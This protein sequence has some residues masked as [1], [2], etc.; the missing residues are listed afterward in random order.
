MK[1][2]FGIWMLGLFLIAGCT[3][4][5][6]SGNPFSDPPAYTN[7]L[8]EESSPYLI[9]QAYQPVDWR[10]WSKASLAEAQQ[11]DKLLLI[12]IG[13]AASHWCQV[14]DQSVFADTVVAREMNTHFLPIKVDREERP[15]LAGWYQRVC[16]LSQQSCGWP[17]Q[18]I[19][20]PDGRPLAVSSMTDVPN[21]LR[22]LKRYQTMYQ[23]QPLEAEIRS[24][25]LANQIHQQE[26]VQLQPTRAHLT[27]EDLFEAM[28]EI[29]RDM[30]SNWGGM[31]EQ[32]KY[33]R[34]VML[35]FL[36]EQH[37]HTHNEWVLRYFNKSLHYLGQGGIY[38]QIGGGF[39]HRAR[40]DA[41]RKPEFEKLLTDNALLLGVFADA[42]RLNQEP[43][44]EQIM[45]ETIEFLQREMK[46]DWGYYSSLAADSEGE[47][48]RYYLWTPV[49]LEVV[50]GEHIDMF[51]RFY[52]LSEAGNWG[53]GLNIPF[54]RLTSEQLAIAYGMDVASFEE[55][56]RQGRDALFT[57]RS[58]RVLP[59]QD[60][61]QIVAWNALMIQSLLKAYQALGEEA[62]LEEARSLGLRLREE[63]LIEG[64]EL[65][66]YRLQGNW[67][68]RGYL[69]DYAQLAQAF[70]DLYA[71]TF[72]PRWIDWA[73]ELTVYAYGTFRDTDQGL[74]YASPQD[75]SSSVG[76]WLEL[77]D[78]GS[79][80]S[81]AIMAQVLIQLGELTSEFAYREEGM[82]MLRQLQSSIQES[83][84]TYASWARILA[85]ETY[86]S[87]Q[88]VIQG[89]E[90]ISL[91][92]ALDPYFLPHVQ[93][94]G[95][96]TPS[97][98]PAFAGMRIPPGKAYLRLCQGEDCQESNIS[99]EEVI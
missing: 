25:E 95:S 75:I 94:M 5:Q 17:L 20:L 46:G 53:T 21:W 35:R 14:M 42:Y 4:Q 62:W 43:E 61:K 15:D 26:Q 96:R 3:G 13:F 90:A 10:S 55:V 81:N 45:Y 82:R 92:S 38:D 7:D 6:L 70:L 27:R 30:D 52:N 93:I 79:P 44:Y 66:R 49:D 40:D 12:S 36:L 22:F 88:V 64:M 18:V 87:Y 59:A 16:A 24:E 31:V 39:F 34:P 80:S 58:K 33:P 57:E 1:L 77:K 32:P 78:S 48:G 85:E 67:Y 47:E 98:L 9:Q 69:E 76:R 56:I 63:V 83:P 99:P 11:A 91:R 8:V 73:E 51:S 19:A 54:R 89:P 65:P 23:R 2:P 72:E 37:I 50:L 97:N 41:W 74:W 60:Q 29:Q 28:E 71:V 68:G 86:P 84:L